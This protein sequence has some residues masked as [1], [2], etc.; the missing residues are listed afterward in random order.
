MYMYP[1][2]ENPQIP[3]SDVTK[4]KMIATLKVELGVMLYN[5]QEA[6][7]VPKNIPHS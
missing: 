3:T 4:W 1:K 6:V 5:K 7:P 2:L